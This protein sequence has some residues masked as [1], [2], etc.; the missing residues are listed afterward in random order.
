VLGIFSK[1]KVLKGARKLFLNININYDILKGKQECFISSQGKR[2]NNMGME[3]KMKQGK[4]PER[5]MYN[6][7]TH[8]GR[9][10]YLK[11]GMVTLTILAGI[12]LGCYAQQQEMHPVEQIA[13]QRAQAQAIPG[14]S[15][16]KAD[17]VVGQKEYSQSLVLADGK[18]TIYWKNDDQYLYMALKG[19]TKGWVAIG[20]EPTR[21]MKDADMVFGWVKDSEVTV[22]D[23][24]STGSFGP[25]P[26]DEE[27]GGTNDLLE[28]GGKEEGG[29]TTIEFKRKMNTKDKYDKI[30]TPGKTLNFIWAMATRDSLTT[31]HNIIKERGKLV[32]E[33]VKEESLPAWMD[34][35]L[36]DIAT[37]E[38]FKIS[39]FKG[40]PIL[41][42]SFA[43]WC[44][45]CL[46]QQREIGKLKAREGDAIIHISIDTDPHEDEARVREHL[47]TYGFDWYFA[48]SPLELTQALVDEF[49]LRVVSAP[50]A[51]VMLICEN[52]STR[53]L[54]S[55]VK[56]SDELLSE[57]NQ[58]C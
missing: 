15:Q 24:Y 31:K 10:T 41:L 35:E 44:P 19:K 16:W 14:A 39:D 5:R 6:V 20:F 55:G 51:P 3:Q 23:L 48:V 56:S 33:A 36:S 49:G 18:Y 28:A 32:L 54:R 40:T 57:I 12:S 58:G 27:L 30:L 2:R 17:G 1:I 46:R 43:V 37:G 8:G 50:S 7:A 9:K 34:I 52:Q 4:Q 45:T 26:P 38:T 22:L 13:S 42:E 53:F 25:H 11:I 47:E 29:Y 21:R